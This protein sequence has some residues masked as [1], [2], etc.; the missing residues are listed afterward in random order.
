VLTSTCRHVVKNMHDHSGDR[1]RAGGGGQLTTRPPVAML[2][3]FICAPTGLPCMSIGSA[4]PVPGSRRLLPNG[5]AS[6]S[7]GR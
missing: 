5:S 3:G 1:A 6:P 7:R 4:K 2:T